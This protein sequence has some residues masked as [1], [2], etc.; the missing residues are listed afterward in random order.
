MFVGCR[1]MIWRVNIIEKI[2]QARFHY[3]EHYI[4]RDEMIKDD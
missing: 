3:V 1:G 4:S 2:N